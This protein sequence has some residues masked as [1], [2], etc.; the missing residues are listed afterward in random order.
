MNEIA[1]TVVKPQIVLGLRKRGGYEEIGVLLPRLCESAIGNNIEITGPPIFLC[2]ETSVED[3]M[4]ADREKNADLEVAIP[5]SKSVE[6]YEDFKCYELPGGKMVRA[7]HRGPYETCPP[8]YERLFAWLADNGK[9]PVG[10]IREVYLNDPSEVPPEEI[11]YE[12]YVP[13]E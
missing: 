1:V 10:P 3:S 5:I 13:I 11:L 7:L 2:H 12:I 9:W 4:R 6:D 8:T